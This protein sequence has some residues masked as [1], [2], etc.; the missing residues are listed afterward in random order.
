MITV[1]H[2]YKSYG[3]SN[4]LSDVSFSLTSGQKVSLV[5]AN[6]VGKST[7]LKIIAGIEKP[8]EGTIEVPSDSCI[9]YLP[10]EIDISQNNTIEEYLKIVSGLKELEE[11]MQKLEC[12]LTDPK[13]LNE[14][15]DLQSIYIHLDGYAFEHR[16]KIALEGFGLTDVAPTTPLKYLSGGQKKKV[17]LAGILLKGVDILLLDEPTNDLDLPALIWLENFLL[18]SRATSIIVSHD[19]RF[20]DKVTSKVFEI[21]RYSR[22][23][24]TY[25]GSYT[26]YLEVK[27]KQLQEQKKL[28]S[29]QQEE[30]KRL[31]EAARQKKEWAKIGANQNVPDHDK[32]SRGVQRD[33][34]AK[35]SKSAKTAEKRLEQMEKLEKPQERLPLTIPLRVQKNKTKSRIHLKEVVAGYKDGFKTEPIN[36]EIEY[37]SRIGILGINGSGKSTLLKT[38]TGEL[39]PIE[40]EV[41]RSPSIIFGN[42]MQEHE[43][44]PR[45]FSLFQFLKN[46][47]QLNDEQTYSLLRHFNFSLDEIKKKIGELSP[48]GRT[49]LLLAYF[50]AI[51][52]NILVLDEPSNHLDLEAIEALTETL[53]TYTGTLILVS[54]DRYLIEQTRLSLLYVL[55]KGKLKFIPSFQ[56]YLTKITNEV[57]LK[58]NQL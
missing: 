13:K 44:L 23:I 32:Y 58:L 4:V 47:A 37:G 55:E 31:K 15:S 7:L 14:Y 38:I 41:I 28:Y 35:L 51:G 29:L 20:L 8:D 22:R 19:R 5:G 39:E 50:A 40:G 1:K 18:K 24:I 53:K 25:T 48:G 43:N 54:H 26:N 17:A 11:K 33:R 36:L 42:L 6:G 52:S 27:E 9:G 2:I 16:M 10:Q 12:N 49:K 3:V 34:A 21:E 30:I 46:K 45:D 56:E 57:R